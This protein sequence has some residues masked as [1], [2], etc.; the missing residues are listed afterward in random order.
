MLLKLQVKL[1]AMPTYLMK[2]INN[3]NQSLAYRQNLI[4]I[5]NQFSPT[6]RNNTPAVFALIKIGNTHSFTIIELNVTKQ[7]IN[8]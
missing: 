5:V 4:K 2:Q 6:N 7:T 3:R 1:C 8:R